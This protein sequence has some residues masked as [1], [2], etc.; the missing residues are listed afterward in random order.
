MFVFMW[1]YRKCPPDS[2][3]KASSRKRGCSARCEKRRCMTQPEATNQPT[4]AD[5]PSF[6][7]FLLHPNLNCNKGRCRGVV[8]EPGRGGLGALP[9]AGVLAD[10]HQ[11]HLRRQVRRGRPLRHLPR[12]SHGLRQLL[13]RHRRSDLGGSPSHGER[14]GAVLTETEKRGT[15]SL[16]NAPLDS[17]YHAAITTPSGN[18]TPACA[19]VQ[20][21]FAPGAHRLK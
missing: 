14:Y 11:R 20:C 21:P 16:W 13:R 18:E 1:M 5:P 12:A 8:P 19:A 17:P 10:G 7:R 2:W 15:P 4:P 9:G 6:C 3:K